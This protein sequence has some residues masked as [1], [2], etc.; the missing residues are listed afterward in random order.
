MFIT[1]II[2]WHITTNTTGNTG[3]VYF[4]KISVNL[5]ENLGKSI[6]IYKNLEKCEKSKNL[7][8]S[9]KDVK[10]VH[11]IGPWPRVIDDV[12]N[13]LFIYIMSQIY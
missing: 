8:F 12:T 2:C 13:V 5:L 10:V 7:G 4:I 1:L 9:E 6:K 11:L 3:D